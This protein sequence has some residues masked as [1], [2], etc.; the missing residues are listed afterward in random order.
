MT[1]YQKSNARP[2]PARREKDEGTASELG[3][4]VHGSRIRHKLGASAFFAT[5]LLAFVTINLFLCWI[6][7]PNLISTSTLFLYNS[8]NKREP[9]QAAQDWTRL[10]IISDSRA[11]SVPKELWFWIATGVFYV[12]I[13]VLAV[14]LLK[15]SP[16][17]WWFP[18][19][20]RAIPRAFLT[21]I[22]D[23]GKRSNNAT[24]RSAAIICVSTLSILVCL[25]FA[26]AI[27]L[28]G[29]SY[30]YWL[31]KPLFCV[32]LS[33]S[34]LAV[35]WRLFQDRMTAIST[36]FAVALG[37][38]PSLAIQSVFKPETA[39]SS[40]M[41]AFAVVV[42]F[43]MAACVFLIWFPIDGPRPLFKIT[44]SNHQAL[45]LLPDCCEAE[46][47]E[48][49]FQVQRNHSLIALFRDTQP[50]N[51]ANHKCTLVNHLKPQSLKLGSYWM[52]D[53]ANLSRIRI[54]ELPSRE[55]QWFVYTGAIHVEGIPF[56][57]LRDGLA[58]MS[59][60]NSYSVSS[61]ELFP[62]IFADSVFQTIISQAWLETIDEMTATSEPIQIKGAIAKLESLR[63]LIQ[64]PVPQAIAQA[65]NVG[66]FEQRMK[67][68]EE[69]LQNCRETSIALIR[70]SD[71]IIDRIGGL[72]NNES[73][74]KIRERML[75]LVKARIGSLV[76]GRFA[77]ANNRD[78]LER[79]YRR[80]NIN[81]SVSFFEIS[82]AK[83]D[84]LDQQRKSTFETAQRMV[85]D[86]EAE[87]KATMDQWMS[88]LS[89]ADFEK[90][91]IVL[92]GLVKRGALRQNDIEAIL[93]KGGIN[94]NKTQSESPPDSFPDGGAGRSGIGQ[95]P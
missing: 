37:V 33:I 7:V 1:T 64:V 14:A 76:L 84:L 55:G 47:P 68:F 15:R 25:F 63:P 38:L 79:L 27:R 29:R 35:L 48:I 32:C 65:E 41:Q 49:Y 82:R 20:V 54:P 30:D 13:S 59:T 74:Q 36:G 93:S 66:I 78:D 39:V 81:I 31:I 26:P 43:L 94:R 12:S 57:M 42:L 83:L 8:L 6:N 18:Q 77:N 9:A 71:K 69:S 88:S 91:V 10:P 45:T 89:N 61:L 16:W 40:E 87:I 70:E 75:E 28:T 19:G 80:V 90:A 85:H 53:Y 4:F 34:V 92:K 50:Q 67:Y 52:L 23:S 2:V 60:S 86:T 72:S 46:M 44:Q 24:R 22:G 11:M 21:A 62:A 17:R 95:V 56:S 73:L 3:A 51:P 58:S 5:T